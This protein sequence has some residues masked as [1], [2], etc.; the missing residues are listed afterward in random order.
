MVEGIRKRNK[1]KRKQCIEKCRKKYPLKKRTGTKKAP[2]AAQKRQQQKM[3]DGA[4]A[5]QKAKKNNKNINYR[6][7]MS[8]YLKK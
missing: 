5:Y 7:F 4:M 1:P 3:K 2:S 6:S 8:K